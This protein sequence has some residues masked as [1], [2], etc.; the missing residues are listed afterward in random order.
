MLALPADLADDDIRSLQGDP[1][2]A[3]TQV[4]RVQPTSEVVWVESIG[5]G[6]T[7]A[8]FFFAFA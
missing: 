2:G 6:D 8:L 7:T 5:A 3:A 4:Q 1:S